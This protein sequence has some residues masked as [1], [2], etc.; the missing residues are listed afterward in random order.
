[1][2]RA[3]I[4]HEK[5]MVERLKDKKFKLVSVSLDEEKKTVADFV[6][7]EKMS[8]THWWAG[9]S[10]GWIEDWNVQFIPTIYVLDGQ[11][12]IRHV[13]L[14]GEELEKAVNVLLKDLEEKKDK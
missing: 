9:R 1:P 8:W 13:G 12:V 7:K 5:E 11:G 3:M 4:P 14:R 6:A 10:A 2:C